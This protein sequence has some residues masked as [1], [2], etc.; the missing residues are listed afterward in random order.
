MER[1]EDGQKKWMGK[2]SRWTEEMDG[3]KSI[4]SDQY[5]IFS[6]PKVVGIFFNFFI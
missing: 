2:E 1:S 6:S 3:K 5:N 4:W